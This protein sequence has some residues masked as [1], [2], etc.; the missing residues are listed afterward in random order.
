M[1]L[2]FQDQPELVRPDGTLDA[3][4]QLLLGSGEPLP[5]PELAAALG[6]DEQTV[7]EAVEGFE[8]AGR[9]R[10]GSDGRLVAAT[11]VSVVPAEYELRIGKLLR[12]T[13]CAKTG[14][15]VLGALAAGGTLATRCPVTGEVVTVVFDGGDPR[16][17]PAAVLWPSESFQRG[18]SSAAGELCATFTLFSGAAGAAGWAAERGLDAE[19]LTVAEATGRSV[20]RYRHSLGLPANRDRLL[21]NTR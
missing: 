17:S 3:A 19:V 12:W 4:C 13:W 14:L 15:G 11:G 20:A 18:C 5:V 1:D 10:R 8:R 7:L 16:P 9:M 6:Q 21:K 2:T